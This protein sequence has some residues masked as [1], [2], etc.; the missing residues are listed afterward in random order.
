MRK[1]LG[2]RLGGNFNSGFSWISSDTAGY[3]PCFLW[4]GYPIVIK[5]NKVK[6][7]GRQSQLCFMLLYNFNAT[8]FGI[9]K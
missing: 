1:V 5:I 8:C 7:K 3:R 4:E 6:G 2:S 9:C